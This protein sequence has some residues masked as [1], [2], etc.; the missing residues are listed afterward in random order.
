MKTSPSTFPFE[1][2]IKGNAPKSRD[3][4]WYPT[5]VEDYRNNLKIE[6]DTD[7]HIALRCN[8]SYNLQY[9]EFLQKELDELEVSSVLESM[10]IKNYVIT[11][12]S[13]LEGIFAY[14]IKNNGWWSTESLEEIKEFTSNQTK[15]NKETIIVKTKLC[16][17]IPEKDVPMERMSLHRFIQILDKHHEGLS[18]N[19]I[20]YKRLNDI[21]DLRNKIHLTCTEKSS[22]HDYNAFNREVQQ[23]MQNILYEILTSKNISHT[24]KQYEFLNP[25]NEK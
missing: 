12:M 23:N 10:I 22:D 15:S 3:H 8:L 1:T 9:L 5:S 20:I 18:V 16:K 4:K 2:L 6:S 19:H 14:V 21:R 7:F 17:V 13:I 24:S 11:G 25:H